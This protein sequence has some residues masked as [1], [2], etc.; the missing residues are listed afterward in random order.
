MRVYDILKNVSNEIL[1]TC[2]IDSYKEVVENFVI[3]RWKYAELDAG[4]FVE[5]VRR[6]L[7]LKLFGTYTPLN[8]R[9]PNFSN[10]EL[11]R[12]EN[13]TGD[14]SYRILIPRTLY[15]IYCIRNKRGAGHLTGVSPN[16]MDATFIIYSVK[17]VLS[18]LVRLNSTLSP[19]QT[20]ALIS[21]IVERQVDLIWKHEGITRI[22]DTTIS[23]NLQVLILLYDE[24]TQSEEKLRKA[25]EY[26]NATNFRGVLRD[27]HSKRLLEYDSEKKICTITP[28]GLGLAE[29]IIKGRQS[30]PQ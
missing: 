29:K 23:K 4:H 9:L 20:L 8:Q 10:A 12:Y 14:E 17:W 24:N 15:S 1:A 7:E 21:S 13:A 11:T 6:F 5:A 25:V 26:A 16:E 22:L 28:K 27:F 18:E 30:T 19:D 3:E 2:I